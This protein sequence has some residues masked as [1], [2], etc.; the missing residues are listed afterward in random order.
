M[1]QEEGK[2]EGPLFLSSYVVTFNTVRNKT[3][4]NAELQ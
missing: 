2:L 1:A 4:E 3:L